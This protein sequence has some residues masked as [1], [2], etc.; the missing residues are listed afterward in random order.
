MDFKDIDPL[1]NTLSP[2]RITEIN[3]HVDDHWGHLRFACDIVCDEI[4]AI[5]KNER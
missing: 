2:E 3:N 4:S 5:L 1:L